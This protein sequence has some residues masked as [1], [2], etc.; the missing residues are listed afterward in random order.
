MQLKLD[1]MRASA[2]EACTVLTALGNPHRLMILCQL[3]DG[4]QR[5]ADLLTATGISQSSLSQHLARL[6][7]DGLVRTRRES[8]AIYY[9]LDSPETARLI[10]TLYDIYCQPACH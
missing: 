1:Q 5:V 9:R 2:L 4:E 6:R 10:R 7:R 8:Q 3:V